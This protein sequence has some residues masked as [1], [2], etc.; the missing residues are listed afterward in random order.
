MDIIDSP[1]SDTGSD[2]SD[3][4]DI[5]EIEDIR[6]IF[7]IKIQ[8]TNKSDD[9]SDYGSQCD[10]ES[11]SHSVYTYDTFDTSDSNIFKKQEIKMELLISNKMSKSNNFDII[12]KKMLDEIKEKTDKKILKKIIASNDSDSDSDYYLRG[13]KFF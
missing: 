11:D 9:S 2:I 12:F 13:Y 3:I 7:E 4:S 1:D 5:S 8:S 10:C 6:K